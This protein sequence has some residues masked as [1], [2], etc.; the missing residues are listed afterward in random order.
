MGG[1]GGVELD[2]VRLVMAVQE[3]LDAAPSDKQETHAH[4]Q[5]ASVT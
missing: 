1:S 2:S 3:L 5:A 4:V